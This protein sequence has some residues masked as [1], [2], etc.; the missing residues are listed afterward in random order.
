M[1]VKSLLRNPWLR[2]S[3][4]AMKLGVESQ[5]VVALRLMKFAGGG[6]GAAA[7]AQLMVTEKIRA[8]VAAQAHLTSSALTGG[9]DG[10]Q[11]AMT[12]YRRRVRA[13]RRRLSRPD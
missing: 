3:L 13:N 4:D 11:R 12:M 7:E 8:A 5:S 9:P 2:L 1:P 10:A 6:P